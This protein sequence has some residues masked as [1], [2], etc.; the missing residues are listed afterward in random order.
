[1][2]NK[3]KQKPTS[4]RNKTRNVAVSDALPLEA[5]SGASRAGF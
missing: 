3:R 1:M 5:A 2:K 4:T